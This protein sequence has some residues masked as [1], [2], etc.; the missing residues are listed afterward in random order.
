MQDLETRRREREGEK[1]REAYIILL[2]FASVLGIITIG[3]IS[4]Y[5]EPPVIKLSNVDTNMVNHIVHVRGVIVEMRKFRNG[6]NILIEEEGFRREAVYFGNLSG[7][8][9]M[10][11]D[12]IGD[13]TSEGGEIKIRARRA[14]TFVC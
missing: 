5:I 13:V 14:N 12:V 2:A 9:G 11:V 8:E 6:V 10:C 1:M 4:P 3:V 7:R